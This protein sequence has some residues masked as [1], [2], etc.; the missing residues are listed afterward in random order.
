MSRDYLLTEKVSIQNY[1]P[2][3]NDLV[4]YFFQGHEKFI[5]TYNCFFYSGDHECLSFEYPW[6][7]YPE[8]TRPTLCRVK[9]MSFGFPSS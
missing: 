5:T 4:Y 7:K 6:R 1:F 8:L 9:N 3:L 2:Q